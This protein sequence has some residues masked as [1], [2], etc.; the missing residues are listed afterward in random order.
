MPEPIDRFV[1]PAPR[2]R[3]VLAWGVIVVIVA[4]EVAWPYVRKARL[5]P[6]ADDASGRVMS[7]MQA[8]YAVGAASLSGQEGGLLYAQLK[9]TLNTGP[10]PQRLRFVTVASELAGPGR[11]LEEIG[12]LRELLGQQ[13]ITPTDDQAAVLDVLGTLYQDYEAERW[14]APSLTDESRAL[15]RREL[16]WCGELAL[17]PRQGPDE[18]ARAAVLAPARRLALS[19]IVL[20]VVGAGLGLLGFAGL[21]LWVVLSVTGHLRPALSPARGHGG[22]YAEAFAVYMVV[23]LGLGVARAFLPPFGPELMVAGAAMLVALAAGLLWP[24]ARGVSWRDVYREV[25]LT[26]GRRPFLEPV[27]GLTGYVLVI[28]TFALGFVVTALLLSLKQRWATGGDPERSFAPLEQPSH[29]IVEWVGRPD[30]PTVLQIVVLASVLAPLVEETMFRGA[31]YRHL[32]EAT[33]RWGRFPSFL[34]SALVVSFVFAAIHP[35]GLLAVPVLMG[36][37]FGLN[38]LREWRGTLGN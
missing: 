8:R 21:A 33:A 26:L 18:A 7:D 15:L 16:G 3:P 11:A 13:E 35:Q 38:V 17:V 37:A 12:R 10:V 6:A 20:F 22:V 5:G 2:G 24:V 34:V 30:L 14:E 25:G 31:L 27:I 23:Y 36:L 1:T 19:L 29:P 4:L 9:Q 28:P 32:R